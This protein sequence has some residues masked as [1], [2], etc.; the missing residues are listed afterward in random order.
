MQADITVEEAQARFD[1]AAQ[2]VEHQ[3]NMTEIAAQ[4]RNRGE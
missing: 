4:S 1:V 2:D 3:H